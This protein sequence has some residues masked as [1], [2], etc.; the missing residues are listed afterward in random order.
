MTEG[1]GSPGAS[2]EGPGGSATP[3]TERRETPSS[4]RYLRLGILAA[5]FML[6]IS[7]LY[8][9]REAPDCWQTSISAYY[10]TPVRSIFVGG[11][12]VIGFSLIVIKGRSYWED[13][14]LNLAGMFAPVVAL[15]P[16]SGTG[17]CFSIPLSA[18]PANTEAAQKELAEWLQ[19]NLHANIQNNM[20]ALLMAGVFAVGFVLIIGRSRSLERSLANPTSRFTYSLLLTMVLLLIGVWSFRRYDFVEENAHYIAAYM[21][22]FFLWVVVVLNQ[23]ITQNAG[24]KRLYRMIWA[25]MLVSVFLLLALDAW[26]LEIKHQTLWLEALEIGLFATFW[27]V[28]TTEQW[29]MMEFPVEV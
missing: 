3:S 14:F 2:T 13:I 24:Y 23:L 1:G 10:Y 19:V 16:T 29:F 25:G 20:L 11:L 17:T 27:V 26:V 15:V 7:V 12:L 8:E 6:A 21:M 9:V 5:V 18:A 22:F 28:E 4:Y